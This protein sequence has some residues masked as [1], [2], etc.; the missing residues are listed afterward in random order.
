VII[1]QNNLGN[2]H[3][4]TVIV[5]PITSRAKTKLPTHLP[6][7]GVSG[8]RSGSVALMEQVRTIDKSRLSKRVGSLSRVGVRLMDAALLKSLALNKTDK[9]SP[10]LMTLCAACA[11]GYFNCSEYKIRRADYKQQFKE[12]CTVCNVRT[13]FDFLVSRV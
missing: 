1:V 3:A 2:T 11:D 8:I 7:N 13:G 6:L 10:L 4:P 5:V 9:E 12:P